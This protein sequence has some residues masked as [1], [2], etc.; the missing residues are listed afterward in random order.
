MRSGRSGGESEK[1]DGGNGDCEL[2]GP[3]PP[4]GLH[5]LHRGTVASR[6]GRPIPIREGIGDVAKAVKHF[7]VR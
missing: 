4:A 6:A 2:P 7:V 3:L 5:V 1:G